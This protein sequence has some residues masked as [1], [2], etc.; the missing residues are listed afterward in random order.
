MRV[1]NEKYMDL[2]QFVYKNGRIDWKE[3]VGKIIEFYYNNEKH[4]IE[5]L[6]YLGL[7]Y[8]KIKMDE[9]IFEKVS[10][11]KILYLRFENELYCPQYKYN[12]GDIINDIEILQQIRIPCKTPLGSGSVLSKGYKCKCLIDGYEFE[13]YES[14]RLNCPVC[15]NKKLIREIND[16]GT[17]NPELLDLFVNKEDAYNNLPT[18][19]K[20][21]EVRCPFCG[22][23]KKMQI[24]YFVAI[25]YVTCDKCSDNISYPNKFAHCLFKQLENQYVEYESEYSPS[26]ANNYIYDNYIVLSNGQKII[27]EMDGKYHYDEKLSKIQKHNDNIKDMLALNHDIIVIRIDCYYNHVIN[28][29]DHIKNN[30][31]NKLSTH[32]DFSNINWDL[33]NQA[34][35]SNK[36]IEVINYYNNNPYSNVNDIM[37]R[38]DL[39]EDTVYNYLNIA[40]SLGLIKYNKYDPMR[41]RNSKPIAMYDVN[42]NLVNVYKSVQFLV[43]NEKNRELNSNAIRKRLTDNQNKPYKGFYF[44][45]ISYDEF[46]KH[47]NI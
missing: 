12:V 40:N 45:Y 27:V 36:M 21:I 17:T 46:M 25:G 26:W 7:S 28:R 4:T 33:C 6:E 15:K 29:F 2:N 42:Y 9:T 34:G 10:V 41:T 24:R 8:L 35:L 31:I 20:Y 43:N 3:N 23:I 44:K 37:V 47:I 14:R 16:I 30:I 39:C 32:F 11:Q 18:S 1:K 13:V 5:I 22:T 19:R 38:F